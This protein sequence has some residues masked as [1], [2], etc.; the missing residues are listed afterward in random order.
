MF[1][2]PHRV[3]HVCEAKSGVKED[4]GNESINPALAQT[5]LAKLYKIYASV[6]K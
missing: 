3:A 4:I 6:F 5:L 1:S 2:S